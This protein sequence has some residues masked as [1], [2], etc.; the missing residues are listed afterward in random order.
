MPSRNT[1]VAATSNIDKVISCGMREWAVSSE[2]VTI[3]SKNP[4]R[5]LTRTTSQSESTCVPQRTSERC[6][7]TDGIAV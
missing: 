1:T 4:S 7:Y 5:L 2:I 3:G 6:G